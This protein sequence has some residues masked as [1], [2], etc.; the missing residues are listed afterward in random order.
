MH[1]F[2]RRKWK[3]RRRRNEMGFSVSGQARQHA[4]GKK[5]GAPS[6]PFR[7]R[8]QPGRGGGLRRTSDRRK[9]RPNLP[10]VWERKKRRG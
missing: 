10:K 6:S 4:R 3:R 2:D 7:P 8:R 9:E 1:F 5:S